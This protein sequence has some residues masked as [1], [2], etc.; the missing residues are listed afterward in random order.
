MSAPAPLLGKTILYQRN[1]IKEYNADT[2]IYYVGGHG[3]EFH[4]IQE[5]P[6][7]ENCTYVT[8]ALCGDY[9]STFTFGDHILCAFSRQDEGIKKPIENYNKLKSQFNSKGNNLMVTQIHVKSRNAVEKMT[10]YTNQRYL[11]FISPE[12]KNGIIPFGKEIATLDASGNCG[13]ISPTPVSFIDYLESPEYNVLTAEQKKDSIREYYLNSYSDSIFPTLEDISTKLGEFPE[14]SDADKPY[15]IKIKLDA[16]FKDIIRDNFR[17][18]Q[19]TLFKYFPGIFYN[20]SCRGF[21]NADPNVEY[22]LKNHLDNDNAHHAN[23]RLRRTKS[24]AGDLEQSKVSPP[25][26]AGGGY[27]KKTRKL[28]R[29]Y[30]K[31]TA[32]K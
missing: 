24:E 8:T 21:T 25:V 19:Q 5:L 17:V 6:V 23:A 3:G 1:I 15:Q 10:T 13:M 22:Q 11:L 18:D 4:P 9:S 12:Q 31:R 7:P 30:R 2:S 14:I 29:R 20:L 16:A 32:R 28:K 27:R 26:R